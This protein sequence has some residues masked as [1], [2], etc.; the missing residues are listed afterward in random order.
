MIGV[1][2]W[3]QEVAA[4]LFRERLTRLMDEI[5]NGLPNE[6]RLLLVNIPDFSVTPRG[7]EYA[8][9]RDI[10]AGLAGF[11]RIIAEEADR[12][13]IFLVDIFPVSQEMRDRP[14]LVA[15]DGLHPSAKAYAEWERIIF[16]LAIASLGR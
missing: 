16:P 2:D 6:N 14:E 15:A 3:V 7:G 4:P 11:N 8:R 5:R 13:G 9:G 10:S 12:R 1:N